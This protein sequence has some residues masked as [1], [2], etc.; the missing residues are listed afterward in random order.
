[1]GDGDRTWMPV[2][3]PGDTAGPEL[4]RQVLDT[5][6]AAVGRGTRDRSE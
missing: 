4:T 3:A 6:L 1:M 5:A 2:I